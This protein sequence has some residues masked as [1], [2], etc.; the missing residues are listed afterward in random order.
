MSIGP[1]IQTSAFLALFKNRSGARLTKLQDIAQFEKR[2]EFP[3]GL[4]DKRFDGT[5]RMV[6]GHKFFRRNQAIHVG[7]RIEFSTH[8]DPIKTPGSVFKVFPT[9]SMNC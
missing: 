3:Q 8:G 1:P 4:I 5:Q 9:F 6:L 7:L 2:R